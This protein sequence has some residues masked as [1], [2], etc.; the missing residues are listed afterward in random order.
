MSRNLG[1]YFEIPATDLDRAIAFYA[2]VFDADF[3]V[4]ELHESRM[5]LF[6]VDRAAHG[7]TGALCAGEAYAPSCNGVL[8]YLRS[9]D[10]AETLAR[11]AA[12]GGSTAF[13]RTEAGDWGFVAEFIDSEGNRIGLHEARP[14]A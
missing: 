10:I 5:A 14:E 6:D 8:I 2:A 11:V 3:E 4:V 1:V 9:A 12:A 13:D 7:I